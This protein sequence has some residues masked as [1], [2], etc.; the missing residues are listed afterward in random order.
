[1][2][3]LKQFSGLEHYGLHIRMLPD[4]CK[5]CALGWARMAPDII[6][7]C[8]QCA[9]METFNHAIPTAIYHPTRLK[10]L[11]IQDLFSLLMIV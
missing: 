5:T 10:V 6:F 8:T 7:L 2:W 11:R 3:W 9:W 1:M 4:T